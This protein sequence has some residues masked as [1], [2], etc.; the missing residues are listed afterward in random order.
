M[1]VKDEDAFE[2]YSNLV[3]CPVLSVMNTLSDSLLPEPNAVDWCS[4]APNTACYIM[5]TS[6]TTGKPKGVVLEHANISCFI[7]YGALHVSKGLG[8]GNRFLNSSPMTFDMSSNIRFSTLSMGATLVLSSRSMLLD[9]LELLINTMKITHICM[10]P[11][12]FELIVKC[13]HPSLVCITLGGECVLQHELEIWRD[14]VKHFLIAYGP[15][16]TDW[17]TALEFDDNTEHA[18]SNIIRF[19][20][21][22]I[23]Y[24]VLDAHM[25]PL[26]VGVMGELYIGGDGVGRGY[27]NRPDLTRKA[28]I[29]NPFSSG[30]GNRIYRTG[31][32]VKLLPDGS[33]FFIGRSD[34]QVN[35][36]GQRMELGE[37]EMALRSVN[38]SVIRAVVLVHKQNLVAFVT[39]G[40]VDGSAVKTG[41]SKVLP[42]YMVPSLVLSMDFIPSTLSGKA[43]HHALL[44]LLV[45]NKA[46]H[47]SVGI[48]S[49]HGQ[50]AIRN[51][52]LEEAVLAIYRMELQSEGMGMASDFFESGGDSLK[53]VRIVAYLRSLH[54]DHPEFQIGKG[55]S[56]LSASDI[57]QH[58]TPSALLQSCLGSSLGMQPFTPEKSIVPRPTEMRLRA[59]ASFQQATMYTGDHLAESQAHSDYNV[60]IQFGA[61]G[62][63]DVD[64]LK[65]A[66]TFLW[67]RHQVLRTR[68]ILQVP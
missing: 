56:A 17:C 25:Q 12:L 29:K 14:R 53:A 22:Y 4:P 36:R 59:P 49:S 60:L 64:A 15:T 27:L 30:D 2:E 67:R 24:Y 42:H 40:S 47:R 34:G 9:E 52:P 6:G 7:Q 45:E 23:T 10:T 8:P 38:S 51:S 63:L 61:I 48:H 37:V 19:P 41:V 21:P 28:F 1:L 35:I 57:L 43:D 54:K 50:H 16:E 13:D 18:S 32:M 55:F 3:K 11:S 39:P 58:R 5:Y 65:M 33:I 66:L 20:L 26:P 62:K 68:L 44:S 31:D 46:A